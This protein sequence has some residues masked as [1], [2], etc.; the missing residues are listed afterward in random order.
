[1]SCGITIKTR[2]EDGA[3]FFTHQCGY[4]IEA[5]GGNP[6]LPPVPYTRADMERNRTER[7]KALCG[8]LPA[9]A[10]RPEPQ[11]GQRSSFDELMEMLKRAESCWVEPP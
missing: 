5:M 4:V 2:A 1:M 10:S 9:A 6:A 8:A 3:L 11:Y 7:I